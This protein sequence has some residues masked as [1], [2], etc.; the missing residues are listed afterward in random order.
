YI[1]A[2]TG[3]RIGS[4]TDGDVG[5]RNVISGNS[6]DGLL[7]EAGSV[8]VRGNIVGLTADGTSGLGN[9]RA[10]LLIDGVTG[11][12]AESNVISDHGFDG[13]A[14]FDGGATIQA[15]RIGTNAAGTAD[16]G[17]DFDGIYVE[18]AGSTDVDILNN[19]IAG[20]DGNG[21]SI[22]D[23]AT[24]ILVQGNTIGIAVG[25]GALGNTDDGVEVEGASTA[26]ILNNAIAFNG[27]L[28]IQIDGPSDNATGVTPNDTGDTDNGPNGL[29]NY[30]VI[31]S[32]TPATA[33]GFD[34]GFALNSAANSE[35]WIEAYTSSQI[36]DSG[37]GEGETL[38]TTTVVTTDASGDAT[39]TVTLAGLASG[40]F[41][42]LTATEYNSAS[43][44]YN[45]TSEF[46]A[47]A[48]TGAELS[49]SQDYRMLAL[50]AGGTVDDLLGPFQTTGFPGADDDASAFCSAYTWDETQGSFDTG[51]ACV[52]SQSAALPA[53]Q[54]LF[55]FIYEDDDPN[56]S[57][58]QGGFPKVISPTG[59][60]VAVPFSDFPLTYTDN[61][62][63][64]AAEEGWNLLGN[65]LATALDWDEVTI[66]GG[67]TQAV[68]VYDPDYL[69]GDYRTWSQGIGGDLTD[70]QIPAFQAFFA[71]AASANPS[72]EVIPPAVV[73]G[74]GSDVYGRG[75]QDQSSPL[76]LT[77]SVA[78]TP[79]SV[80]FVAPAEGAALGV[81]TRD[82][83]RLTPGAW[84]RAVLS[85]HGIGD[86][87]PVGLAL[88]ALPAEASGE[89]RVPLTIALEGYAPGQTSL[90]LTWDALPDGWTATL[91]DTE[92]QTSVPLAEPGDYRF[93]VT[94]EEGASDARTMALGLPLL[95]APTMASRSS[96]AA[97]TGDR[98]ALLL[99]RGT[100]VSTEAPAGDVFGIRAPAPN[101]TR[102]TTRVRFSLAEA[103]EVRVSVHDLLGREVAV[104]ADGTY[105]AGPHDATLD[106]RTLAPG[107]YVVRL[108]QSAQTDATR[109]TVVR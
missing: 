53:G 57:G 2:G 49:G 99:S 34:V 33:G 94:V 12:L 38:A 41:V 48:G 96:G 91:V 16:F 100:V 9:G 71:Q 19:L 90:A 7:I 47:T 30:P 70:G 10:G 85:T 26:T 46:S 13:I 28:G 86:A 80:A 68:Y 87:D 102:G 56:A 52:T 59:P 54:G 11:V 75:A 15:N 98:F 24:G 3:T 55:A 66:T 20:N 83:L 74:G 5:E 93:T 8:V 4:D 101:P 78:G 69:G 82:A 21:V 44:E 1:A 58:T 63:T 103:G 81:D 31:T 23:G 107:V 27:S 73:T 17:N 76:R 18:G 79:V 39:G 105:S 65:P 25:G 42:S 14:V 6:T 97:D 32:V 108:A 45:A 61:P 40:G 95:P 64:A 35:Y 84:P 60:G 50:P 88:N 43:G 22:R 77:L 29:Q 106:S 36:D 72:L 89:I 104:L 67:L 92:T 37:H 51:Y 62:G 109:L